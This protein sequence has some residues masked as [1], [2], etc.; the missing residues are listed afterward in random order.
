M[1]L[2]MYVRLRNLHVKLVH[3]HNAIV[4]LWSHLIF[5]GE[6]EVEYE[7]RPMA[8]SVRNLVVITFVKTSELCECQLLHA[9]QS[10]HGETILFDSQKKNSN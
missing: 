8:T 2:S 1:G 10:Y 9:I 5:A 4:T 3:T 7:I 6:S